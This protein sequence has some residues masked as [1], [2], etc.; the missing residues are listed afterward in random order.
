MKTLVSTDVVDSTRLNESLGDAVMGP[1]WQAHDAAARKLMQIWSG[2]E[3]ARSDGFL[4]VFADPT[5]AV[6]FAAAYHEAL[7]LLDSRLK[8]RV[9]IHAGEFSL[10]QN[11]ELDR[12]RGAPVFEIDGISLPL[13]SRV[14]AAATGGQTLLTARAAQA[15]AGTTFRVEQHGYWRLKGVSDP[16]ELFEA[17]RETG[18]FQPPPDSAKAYRVVKIDGE[19]TPLQSIPNNLPAERDAFVGREDAVRRLQGLVDGPSRLVTILGIGGIGKTRLALRYARGWLG[20]YPGGAWFCDLSTARTSEAISY[21]VAQTL[22]IQVGKADPDEPIV[23]ALAGR[24]PCLLILDN[25]EQVARYAEATVGRWMARAADAKFLVTSREILGIAGEQTFVLPPLSVAEG[26]RLFECRAAAASGNMAR[27]TADQDAIG[28]LVRLLDGLPLA[29]ELAAARSRVMSPTML[30]KRMNERFTVLAARGGRI[31]RQ[32]TLRS[33]LDWSWDLL[34]NNEKSTLA[35]LSVFEGGFN[36]AAV[37]AVVHAGSK[38]G[39][40]AALDLLQSLLDKSFVRQAGEDRFGLLQTVQEYAAQH[41]RAD[42]RFEGSG[43]KAALATEARH[44]EYFARLTEEEVTRA[45]CV[46]LDNLAAACRRAIV[47]QRGLS[48]V[49]RTRDRKP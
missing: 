27:T 40:V 6:E 4:L 16:L 49:A 15:L 5:N 35:Q 7:E 8:A 36:L 30:L 11:S 18:P 19:W 12:I 38:D 47:P 37:E 32:V 48:S 28:D 29:I 14:M 41:L 3:V 25:L 34:S 46:E 31:D 26:A 33:T 21:A 22:D 1:L 45:S 39:A 17:G 24:G 43:P 2:Q 9:G 23:A 44:G 20:D 42:G 10:R 13:V